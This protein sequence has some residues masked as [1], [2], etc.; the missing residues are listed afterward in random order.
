MAYAGPTDQLQALSRSSSLD[1]HVW[2]DVGNAAPGDI[3]RSIDRAEQRV[4]EEDQFVGGIEPFDVESRV[5]LC[6]AARLGF[7]E[8]IEILIPFLLHF[9]QD[10][11][12]RAV[13]NPFDAENLSPCEADL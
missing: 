10:K 9:G 11:V 5:R 12:G 4:G 7:V 2:R 6:D 1:D 3:T 8:G 13:Q